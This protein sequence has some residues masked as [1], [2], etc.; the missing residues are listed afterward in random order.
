M[1]D[2]KIPL[3]YLVYSVLPLDAKVHKLGADKYGER[4]WLSQPILSST[5]EGA[6]L[7]HFLAWAGGED[8]DPESGV[9]H[10]AHIRACCAILI[11]SEING[12]LVDNRTRTETKG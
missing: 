3:E 2:N 4:N 9:T 1:K 5:Y 8:K 7:R 12:T 6:I 10:L 11:D